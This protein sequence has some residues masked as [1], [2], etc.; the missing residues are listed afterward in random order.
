M[1]VDYLKKLVV[2][3]GTDVDVLIA[4]RGD[5]KSLAQNY[6]DL[7]L[8]TPD[9]ISDKIVE[10]ENEIKSQVRADRLAQLK[11]LEAKKAALMSRDE[12]RDLI[13]KQIVALKEQ[14]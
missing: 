6:D 2:R 3:S 8:D 7:K 11:K 10:V 9:W 4:A 13:D 1:N 14:I 5:L 12:R